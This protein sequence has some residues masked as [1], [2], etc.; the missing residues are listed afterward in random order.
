MVLQDCQANQLYHKEVEC[1]YVNGLVVPSLLMESEEGQVSS[2][3]PWRRQWHPTPVLLPGESH[4]QRSL[5]GYT[6]HGIPKLDTTEWLTQSFFTVIIWIFGRMSLRFSGAH[7]AR[8]RRFGRE[9]KLDICSCFWTS[10]EIPGLAS[11]HWVF[12][13]IMDSS[14]PLCSQVLRGYRMW[15]T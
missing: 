10:L 7:F 9:R 5:T 15:Q 2:P 8:C 12:T 4:G 13:L 3:L 6:V 11:C 1:W 14:W